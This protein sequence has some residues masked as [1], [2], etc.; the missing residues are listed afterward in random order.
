MQ[1][2][3]LKIMKGNRKPNSK[4]TNTYVYPRDLTEYFV[5][6]KYSTK[7]SSIDGKRLSLSA[8][9]VKTIL[10][11]INMLLSNMLS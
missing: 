3:S 4:G 2:L 11:E 6:M 9:F 10:K 7:F 1:H 8:Q 5:N